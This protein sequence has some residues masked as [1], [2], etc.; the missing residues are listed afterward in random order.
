VT[1]DQARADLETIADRLALEYSREQEGWGVTVAPLHDDLVGEIRPALLLLQGAVFVVLLIA[2]VN[3]ANLQLARGSV[4]HGEF[5]VRT[6]LGAGRGRLARQ[7]LTE[8]LLLAAR[9]SR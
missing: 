8:S 2:C 5:A 3:V 4:R 7:L 6:A 9:R 1:L